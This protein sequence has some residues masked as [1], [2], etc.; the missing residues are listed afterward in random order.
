[1]SLVRPPFP[2]VIDSTI[3]SAF[4]S[5]PQRAFREYVQHYKTRNQSIH[6]HAG[7]A[8]AR[9]LEVARK[10]FHTEGL[11]AQTSVAEGLRAL[12]E[13]WGDYEAPDDAAKSLTRMLGALEYYFS[14]WPLDNDEAPPATLPSGEKAIEFSFN[15]PLDIRHP[16][17]GDPILYCGRMDM[18]AEYAGGLFG[19]DD[20]TT[21]SLGAS[22]A[23]QWDLRSQFTG[24]CWGAQRSGLLLQGFLVR[25]VSILKT[26]Y[27]HMPA[28]TYR[29]EWFIDRWLEQT[30]RDITR[31]IQCW[32]SGWWDYSLD[33]ACNEYGGCIFKNICLSKDP[34]PWLQSQFERR[35]WDPVGRTEVIL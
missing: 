1:M 35:V 22:W 20:K 8:F 16:E 2:M 11:D 24:Y 3:L 5:C 12:V 19:E 17:S 13:F 10:S 14:V 9:G 7:A 30:H 32:E 27:D 26:K 25:G 29:P 6:L 15:E 23:K 21:S 33:A 18:I 4:R 28:I 34:E 31:M